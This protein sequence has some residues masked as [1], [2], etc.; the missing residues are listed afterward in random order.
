MGKNIGICHVRNMLR[1]AAMC[2]LSVLGAAT[3]NGE[4][5]VRL[6]GY[7][8]FSDRERIVVVS[9][10]K[11]HSTGSLIRLVHSDGTRAIGPSQFEEGDRIIATGVWQGTG[12]TR[13]FLAG[14]ITKK[15]RVDLDEPHTPKAYDLRRGYLHLR[16]VKF[17]GRLGSV[18]YETDANG[19]VRAYLGIYFPQKKIHTACVHG[20]VS[21]LD[22]ELGSKV[23]VRGVV[24]NVFDSKGVALGT[25]IEVSSPANVRVLVRAPVDT[26]QVAAIT[27]IVLLFVAILALAAAWTRSLRRRRKLEVIVAE[28]KRIACEL[29]DNLE[30]H[31]AGAKILI[32]GALRIRDVPDS[33]RMLLRQAAQV[34]ANAKV[35]VRD[36]VL[37]LRN[38]EILALT[39]AAAMKSIASRLAATGTVRVRTRL[40]ALPGKLATGLQRDLLAIVREAITNAIKHGH[41]KNIAIVADPADR[42]FIL[43]V[44]NDGEP[45]NIDEALGPETAHFGLAGMR[46]RAVRSGMK[47]SFGTKGRWTGV[48]IEI[49]GAE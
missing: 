30:Q 44:M 6:R 28:R 27:L 22:L 39:P 2:A 48:S 34:M 15:G 12:K 7:V 29:H 46:E 1:C 24:F 45:F 33:A 31:F 43:R 17:A 5:V 37:D 21:K 47:I 16:R 42:G 18:N 36:A 4:D 35:E 26:L 41:A 25:Q 49:G 40:G 13:E 23:E 9:D 10:S 8:T 38:D 19:D 3:A 11:P 32:A 14:S 20:D